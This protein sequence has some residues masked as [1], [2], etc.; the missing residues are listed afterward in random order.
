[1]NS[2]R[3][4]WSTFSETIKTTPRR[5]GK[6]GNLTMYEDDHNFDYEAACMNMQADYMEWLWNEIDKWCDLHPNYTD[7]E[8]DRFISS[9][10]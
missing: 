1:M 3:M 8:L 5:A 6:H 10:R 7:A 2:E 4:I 9:I